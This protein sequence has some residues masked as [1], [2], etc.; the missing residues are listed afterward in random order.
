MITE[1]EQILSGGYTHVLVFSGRNCAPQ[2][3]RAVGSA[4]EGEVICLVTHTSYSR[5]PASRTPEEVGALERHKIATRIDVNFAVVVVVVVRIARV[6][7]R[8]PGAV[9]LGEGQEALEIFD[10]RRR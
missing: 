9:K 8:G 3:K 7:A 5:W 2:P 4:F 10:R 1:R 6:Y